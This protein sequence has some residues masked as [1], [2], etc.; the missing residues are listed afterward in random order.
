MRLR[1]P[2]L[3]G[4]LL[5]V[6]ACGG[7]PSDGSAGS[8]GSGGGSGRPGTGGLDLAGRTFLSTGVTVD[9]KDRPLAAG[10]T[11]RLSFEQDRIALQAGCNSMGG[12]VAIDGGR[13]TLTD[14][15]LTSTEMGC[16]Q[17]LMAQ[18]SWLAGLVTAGSDLA[19]DGDRLT[20]TSG[21]TRVSL[22][23]ERIAVPDAE[24]LETTWLLDSVGRGDT[25]SSI[26]A[27]TTP[28]L[29][30]SAASG[31]RAG[32]VTVQT[33]CNSGRGPVTVSGTT[34]LLGAVATTRRACVDPGAAEVEKAFLSLLESGQQV[35]ITLKGDRL[36]LTRGD[37]S[38]VFRAGPTQ[39]LQTP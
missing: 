18:D 5:L 17:P 7:A 19:L 15:G 37:L 38:L 32:T 1:I 21:G 12:P 9:G 8:G 26:A 24:L 35:R 22:L 34:L 4:V 14:G 16:P 33:G 2:T 31:T 39:T 27:G 25:V 30:L 23:D 20:L 11:I 6:T 3:L 29:R 36:T 10:S 28:T 13:M